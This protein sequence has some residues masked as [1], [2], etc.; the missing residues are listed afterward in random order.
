MQADKKSCRACA[1][2]LVSEIE[3]QTAAT[4]TAGSAAGLFLSA[5]AG[6]TA[7]LLFSAATAST[8][9]FL[10]S[11][12][13]RST[14]GLAIFAAC[15]L[16]AAL[17]IATAVTATRFF[18]ATAGTAAGSFVTVIV[19]FGRFAA[20]E[21]ERSENKEHQRK[22]FFCHNRISV[23]LGGIEDLCSAES[24]RNGTVG[25]FVL[26]CNFNNAKVFGKLLIGSDFH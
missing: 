4:L 1:L 21:E 24:K 23:E 10:F 5:S 18:A 14:A 7:R 9:G 11:A 17:L 22:K 19:T 2:Q 8:A 15:F 25:P 6:T 16:S 13:A 3:S 20:R 26:E 12:A